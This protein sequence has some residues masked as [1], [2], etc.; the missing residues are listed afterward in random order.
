MFLK[1]KVYKIYVCQPSHH[2]EAC[3]M[4][5]RDNTGAVKIH[6]AQCDN[7]LTEACIEMLAWTQKIK[8]HLN[9]LEAVAGDF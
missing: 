5:H 4:E 6:F 1:S 8:V 9:H 7:A 3:F 2:S